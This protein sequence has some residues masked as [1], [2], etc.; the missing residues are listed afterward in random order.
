IENGRSS[1]RSWRSSASFTT[2][3]RVQP[4]RISLP[5]CR[6][7]STS[8]LVR[9]KADDEPPSVTLPSSIIQASP[10]PASVAACLAST[11]ASSATLLMSR[12]VQRISGMVMT[13][14]PVLADG[15]LTISLTVVNMIKVGDAFRKCE[16]ARLVGTARNLEID[17]A[18]DELVARDQ[19]F[20]DFR[21]PLERLRQI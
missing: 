4:G 14:M 21:N 13:P 16:I 17:H 1:T 18:V 9:M 20:L 10:A 12:L 19:L 3:L 6:V 15:A 2:A 8:S 7:T 11:C 5:F